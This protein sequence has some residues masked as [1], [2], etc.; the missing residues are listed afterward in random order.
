MGSPGLELN[1]GVMTLYMHTGRTDKPVQN[2]LLKRILFCCCE[3]YIIHL[4]VGFELA[5]PYGQCGKIGTGFDAGRVN[6]F[7]KSI[8]IHVQFLNDSFFI[9]LTWLA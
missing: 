3:L 8:S 7:H 4:G 1:I 2:M 9:L 5:P 6:S